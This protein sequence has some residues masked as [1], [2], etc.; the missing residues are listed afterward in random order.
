VEHLARTCTIP[1]LASHAAAMQALLWL[2]R[3]NKEVARH[4]I[5]EAKLSV[6]DELSYSHE[7]EHVAFARV[8]LALGQYDAALPF[9]HRLLL[10]AEAGGRMRKVI[11]VLL[12]QAIGYTHVQKGT[13]R[14]MTALSQA[15]SLAQPEGYVRIFADEGPPMLSLLSAFRTFPAQQSHVSQHDVQQYVEKLLTI[16]GEDQSPARNGLSPA[17]KSLSTRDQLPVELLS[18]REIEI[19]QFI[20]AGMSN[21][22]I[23]QQMVITVGTVKWH[24]ANIYGKLNVHSRTQALARTSDLGLLP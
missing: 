7:F 12:L 5:Q 23:A 14:A 20:A 16:L 17:P 3:G 6:N 8:L 1:L 24:L 13:S 21:L 10:A 15:L 22:E 9:L 4:W 19:M 11:E 18:E 2:A